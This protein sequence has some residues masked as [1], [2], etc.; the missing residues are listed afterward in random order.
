MSPRRGAV[1][2]LTMVSLVSLNPEALKPGL[3]PEV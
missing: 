2:M 3:K 1:V